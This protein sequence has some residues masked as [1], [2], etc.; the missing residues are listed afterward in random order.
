MTAVYLAGPDVFLPE[1]GQLARMQKALCYRH[2]FEPRHPFDQATLSS[3]GIFRTNVGMIRDADA[4]V[5]NLNPFRGAEVDSGTAFE[6]G[7]A[8][9]LGKTVIGYVSRPE[10]LMQRVERLHGNLTYD[11]QAD[12]WRDRDGNL[13]EDFGHAVNLMLAESCTSIVV[14]DLEDA[15][16]RL[17]E[18]RA[19]AGNGTLELL[20]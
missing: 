13:V 11:A 12:L 10:N 15:L 4:V 6:I 19:A 18:C 2:G 5:A 20:R 1:A 8:A 16:A 7:F 3:P 9:A 17:D 14:G